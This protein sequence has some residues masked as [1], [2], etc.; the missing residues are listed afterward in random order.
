MCTRKYSTENH[1]IVYAHRGPEVI[2]CF[3]GMK[4]LGIAGSAPCWIAQVQPWSNAYFSLITFDKLHLSN[5]PYLQKLKF[6]RGSSGGA[7]PGFA[8]AGKACVIQCSY[9]FP[10]M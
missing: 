9:R 7:S 10:T 2:R 5:R 1:L 4:L 8:L 3:S 6:G